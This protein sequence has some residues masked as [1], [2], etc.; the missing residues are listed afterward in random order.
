MVNEKPEDK[1]KFLVQSGI[2]IAGAAASSAIG[3]FAAGPF[4]A[5]CAGAFGVL[6][7]KSLAQEA[8]KAMSAREQ[9]RVGSVAAFAIARIAERL[10]NGDGPRSDFF[11]PTTAFQSDG[12]QL[13]EGVLLKARDEYEERKLYHLG[14]FYGNLVFAKVSVSV[15]SLLIK[16]F[17]RLTYR[18]LVLLALIHQSNTINVKNL[19]SQNHADP[20]LEALKREEMELHGNSFG[21]AGLVCGAGPFDDALSPLGIILVELA[22]VGEI[23]GSAMSEITALIARCP[24]SGGI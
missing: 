11:A 2:E 6:L 19:R 1:A 4:S 3:F 7:A 8:D 16:T 9:Q 13:L 23:S 17:E 24:E 22:E 21:S 12:A 15:A 10:A 18:Q 20:E 5:A 14:C